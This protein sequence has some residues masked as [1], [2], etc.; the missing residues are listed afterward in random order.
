[1]A[2]Q[3]AL[4][5]DN[6][7][8]ARGGNLQKAPHRASDYRVCWSAPL[9]MRG[10]DCSPNPHEQHMGLGLLTLRIQSP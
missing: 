4:L 7:A 5:L 1:M 2:T 6:T 8:L 10:G 9:D 3:H